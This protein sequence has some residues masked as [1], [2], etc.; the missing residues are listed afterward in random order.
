MA[1]VP[2]TEDYYMVLEV[3]PTASPDLVVRSYRR[4]ARKLHPDRNNKHDATEAF[5]LLGIAYETLKDETKRRAYDSIYPTIT[6]P[7]PGSTPQ[8]GALSEAAQ[9]AAHQKSKQERTAQWLRKK[10]ASASSIFE[11]QRGIRQLEQEIKNLDSIVAAEAAA[12]AQK[13]SWGTWFLSPIYKTVKDT[14]EEKERKDNER[15]ARKGGKDM[16]ERQLGSKN[17]DLKKEESLLRNAKEEV[18]TANLVDDGKIRVIKERIWAREQRER[19]TKERERQ[20]KERV[21]RE[22]RARIWKEQQE[23]AEKLERESLEALIAHRERERVAEQRRQA[24]FTAEGSCYH[25]GWWLE[26]QGR[27]ACPKCNDVWKYLLEC[28][29]CMTKA[30]PKCQSAIRPRRRNTARTNRI[31]PRAPSPNYYYDY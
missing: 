1:P 31:P 13:N 7:P 6:R 14:E 2:I 26:V 15:Q 20:E 3:G 27:T 9:I 5:Q 16:K 21:E 17:A 22:K 8:S 29:G 11:L 10:I 28:P 12:E 23:Q 30:C 19:Q 18:D 25:D 4:L 24:F